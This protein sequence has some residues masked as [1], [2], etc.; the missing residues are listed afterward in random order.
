MIEHKL[1][2]DNELWIYPVTFVSS[3]NIH[4]SPFFTLYKMQSNEQTYNLTPTLYHFK[5]S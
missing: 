3:L 4:Y 2:D 1:I 5:M